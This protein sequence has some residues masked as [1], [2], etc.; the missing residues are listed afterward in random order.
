MFCWSQAKALEIAVLPR[1]L[2]DAD[3]ESETNETLKRQE[4]ISEKD[5]NTQK[6]GSGTSFFFLLLQLVVFTKTNAQSAQTSPSSFS[7]KTDPCLRTIS[8][9]STP[10]RRKTGEKTTFFLP[11]VLHSNPSR[12]RNTETSAK[13]EFSASKTENE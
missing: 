8:E 11:L 13:I 1:F 3:A 10:K 7:S 6:K 5:Q 4:G 9:F 12:P 2:R